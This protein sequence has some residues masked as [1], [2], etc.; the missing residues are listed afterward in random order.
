MFD[1][2]PDLSEGEEEGNMGEDESAKRPA[3]DEATRQPQSDRPF[4]KTTLQQLRER[5]DNTLCLVAHLYH[6]LALR[7]D[8]RMCYIATKPYMDEYNFS[9]E[10][11]KSQDCGLF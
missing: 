6:D 10:C 4:D 3:S 2:E 7:D 1:G 11:Q 5:F 8:C 9:L